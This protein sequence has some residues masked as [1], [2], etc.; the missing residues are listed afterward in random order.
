MSKIDKAAKSI[1]KFFG[2]EE[3]PKRESW[4]AFEYDKEETSDK[5][6]KPKRRGND[7]T[8]FGGELGGRI[9]EN[10]RKHRSKKKGKKLSGTWVGDPDEENA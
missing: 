1:R 3:K 10:I 4:D 8:K 9:N 2:V 6:D 5:S 7:K